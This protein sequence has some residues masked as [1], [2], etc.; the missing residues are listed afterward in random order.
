MGRFQ[1]GAATALPIWAKHMKEIHKNL[2]PK[3]FSYK[4]NRN[5]AKN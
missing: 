2:P 3:D 5:Y 4:R 1:T